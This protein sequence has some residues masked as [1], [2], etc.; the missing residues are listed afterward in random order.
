LVMIDPSS[1]RLTCPTSWFFKGA[2]SP[3]GD[4]FVGGWI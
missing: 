3:F 4:M 1:S 2:L